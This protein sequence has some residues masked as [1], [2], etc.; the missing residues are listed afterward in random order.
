MVF[1][2]SSATPQPSR[3]QVPPL[4]RSTSDRSLPATSVGCPSSLRSVVL[5]ELGGRPIHPEAFEILCQQP[6]WGNLPE[7]TASMGALRALPPGAL[8]IGRTRRV[9]EL[10]RQA[11]DA[12]VQSWLDTIA[13]CCGVAEPA[14]LDLG[15][16]R[17]I[18]RAHLLIVRSGAGLI[19]HV[20]PGAGLPVLAGPLHA[21]PQRVMPGANLDL[22]IAGELTL[23]SGTALGAT[24]Y[25]Q[26]FVFAGAV[27]F[28]EHAEQAMRRVEAARQP[29]G[30]TRMA[31]IVQ[32]AS[33]EPNR[34][35]GLRVWVLNAQEEAML[36]EVLMTFSGGRLKGH[37]LRS[38]R[39]DSSQPT[40]AWA[41]SSSTRPAC[42]STSCA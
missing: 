10:R 42:R 35:P 2:T 16:L 29:L 41:T 31:T 8:L 40:N 30:A 27:A 32:G 19:A 22:G 28:E 39:S 20:M 25:L 7:L 12:R 14:T 4:R 9:E 11:S 6:W 3:L 37:I 36:V 5:S 17:R 26:M 21:A 23:M 34:N 33:V 1:A 18:S 15:L 24:P 13:S 38:L